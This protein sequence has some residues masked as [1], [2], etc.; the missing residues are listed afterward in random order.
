MLFRSIKVALTLLLL[1]SGAGFALTTRQLV[2]TPG[3]PTATLDGRS[4]TLQNA[5]RIDGGRVLVPL[6]ETLTLLGLPAVNVN[7]VPLEESGAVLVDSQTFVDLRWLGTASKL[8][9]DI[10]PD[11]ARVTITT[12]NAPTLDPGAPQARFAP[13]KSTYAPGERV[14]YVEYSFDPEGQAITKRE[15]TGRQD[16]F[17][18][19]GDYVVSLQVTNAQGKMSA[20]HTRVVKVRGAAVATPLQFALRHTALGDTFSDS[21]VASYPSL[22]IRGDANENFPLLFSDSPEKPSTAG[23]LY[24]DVVS[25]RAR[26]LAYHV[27]GLSVPARVQVI[28]RNVDARPV[29]IR[30]LG[31]GETAPSRTE[32][33]LGQV[34]L[35]DYFT[36]EA[37]P[38]FE[39]LPGR[40][41]AVYISPSL[42]IGAGVN[43]VQDIEADG[44]VELSFVILPDDAVPTPE[45]LG[46]LPILPLDALHQRGTFLGAV[47]R[48]QVTLGTLPARLN[49]GDGVTDTGLVGTDVLTGTPMRLAGNYGV[50]YDVEVLGAANTVMALSP[51]GGLYRGALQ[52][53]DADVTST[54]RVPRSGVLTNPE[55]PLLLWRSQSE[56][57]N[58]KF[59]PANG[60]NLP[61]SLVFYRARP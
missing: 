22:P 32:G 33:T 1:G 19:P 54:V 34:A 31:K 18:A 49:I 48:V 23:V 59:V 6:V 61:V 15:W 44:R 2:V 51:R 55:R 57:L 60:S 37:S 4:L 40:F 24:R 56:R 8:T 9:F 25:G 43:L 42:P 50:L 26:L 20:P 21:L 27:N 41:S 35:L 29:T 47:R 3:T 7:D 5:P 45:T 53:F 52:V 38:Q 10:S 17:F 12:Q 11:N 58:F 46:A 13:E 28:A 36:S 39:L 30:S 16:A 14:T